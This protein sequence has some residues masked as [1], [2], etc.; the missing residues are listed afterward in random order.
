[1]KRTFMLGLFFGMGAFAAQAN[2]FPQKPITLIVTTSAGGPN[3]TVGRLVAAYLGDELKTSVVVENIA[4]SGGSIAAKKAADAKPDGYTLLLMSTSLVVN[5]SLYPTVQYDPV[6][7]YRPIGGIGRSPHILAASPALNLKTIT[8]VVAAA[9]KRP[10][11]LTYGSGG[12]GTT[13]HL[14]MELFKRLAKIDV[15]HVPY[16]GAAP[17][18]LDAA[19]GRVDLVMFPVPSIEQLVRT[20][21]LTGIA[22]TDSKRVEGLPN[23]PSAQESGMKDLNVL[24]WWG[25]VAPAKIPAEVG[26][27]LESALQRALSQPKLQQSLKAQG[28]IVESGSAKDFGKLINSETARWKEILRISGAKVD[29]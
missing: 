17:A 18:M 10:G 19:A 6:V 2:T 29:N 24:G 28:L 27:T 16:K 8:E 1:M 25:L 9:A 12:N 13:S 20:Q 14:G 7:S 4:G 26:N 23:V 15:L 3:D 21:K 22:I 11:V 5:P